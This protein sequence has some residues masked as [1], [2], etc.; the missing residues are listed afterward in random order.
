ML[1]AAG[2]TDSAIIHYWA[3]RKGYRSYAVAAASLRLPQFSVAREMAAEDR[4]VF[5][6]H[7]Y[8]RVGP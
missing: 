3:L 2:T 5:L 6:Q 4:R 8:I 1:A 7:V